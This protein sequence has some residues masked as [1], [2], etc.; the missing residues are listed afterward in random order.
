MKYLFKAI[1][2]LLMNFFG[3]MLWCISQAFILLWHFDFKHNKT[4]T[5]YIEELGVPEISLIT[6]SVIFLVVAMITAIIGFGQIGS[7]EFSIIC[8][9]MFFVF[10]V[11]FVLSLIASGFRHVE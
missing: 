6:W 9:I 10:L 2:F 5:D 4:Y 1:G 7:M 3:L 8:K 11:L